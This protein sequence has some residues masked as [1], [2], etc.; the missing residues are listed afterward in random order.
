MTRTIRVTVTEEVIE[1]RTIEV[2]VPDDLNVVENG[3]ALNDVLEEA[4][5]EGAYREVPNTNEV[6]VEERYFHD[7]EILNTETPA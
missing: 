4:F 3:E 7:V 1:R 6:S 2:E 5:I